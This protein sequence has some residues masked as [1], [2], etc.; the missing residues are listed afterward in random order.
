MK[1]LKLAALIAVSGLVIA[2]CTRETVPPASKGKILSGSGYSVDVK[3]PGKFWMP[4]WHSLVILDTSTQTMAEK[5][6]V[7]MKDDLDLTFHVNFRTRING[8]EDVINAMFNDIR[9][10][11]YNVTLPMVYK[12]YGRDVVQNSA[13]SVVSKYLTKDVSRNYDKLNEDLF[14]H[15]SD[16]L[17]DSPLDISNVNI[18]NIQW[19]TVITEAIET[20]QEREL[21]IETER[22]SQAVR[23]IV[24]DNELEMAKADYAIRMKNAEAIRDENRITAEGMNP[25]LLEYRRLEV[26]EKM[27]ENQNAVFVPYEGLT[28]PGLQN[29]MYSK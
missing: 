22:N 19:P 2:G 21:A 25:M 26:L 11:D 17:K 15:L 10:M 8:S 28:S 23:M 5:V 1:K 4:W 20:Q 6:T 16:A 13:R 3:E 29:R 12:V 14:A 9:H 27:A 18:G 7:K 24:K